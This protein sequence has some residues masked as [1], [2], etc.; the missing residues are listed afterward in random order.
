MSLRSNDTNELKKA[1]LAE[2]LADKEYIRKFRMFFTG[3]IFAI[4]SFVRSHPIST[5][6]SYIKIIEITA[7]SCL[8]ISGFWR[9]QVASAIAYF[10]CSNFPCY[11]YHT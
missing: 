1:E 10:L 2:R 3:L 11:S 4:I 7:L 8:L 5:T 6:S 9:I